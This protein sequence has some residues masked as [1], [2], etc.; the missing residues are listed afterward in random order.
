IAAAHDVSGATGGR[1]V[2]LAWT[3]GLRTS[4]RATFGDRPW[5]GE[6]QARTIDQRKRV[7]ATTRSDDTGAFAFAGLP[8]GRWVL[9]TPDMTPWAEM[10]VD[11]GA[12]GL[13]LDLARG[14]HRNL[15]SGR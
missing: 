12:D 14:R 3:P 15:R 10:E 1:E 6:I 11:A 4:G 5:S 7:I 13:I 8:P 2:E 9:Y